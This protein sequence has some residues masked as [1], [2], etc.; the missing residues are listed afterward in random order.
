MKLPAQQLEEALKVAPDLKEPLAKAAKLD[1]K[2]IPK[3]TLRVLGFDDPSV[4]EE[5]EV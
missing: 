2:S 1:K 5:P 3:A 4:P